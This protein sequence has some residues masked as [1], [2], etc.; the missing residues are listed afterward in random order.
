MY[1]QFEN[2]TPPTPPPSPPPPIPLTGTSR[3]PLTHNWFVFEL[4]YPFLEKRGSFRPSF[5]FFQE[6][7]TNL[8]RNEPRFGTIMVKSGP[9]MVQHGPQMVQNGPKLVKNGP[10]MVKN[11]P[12]MVSQV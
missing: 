10:K 4:F 5:V 9:K 6:K 8:G 2:I 1:Q 12:K 7:N 11:G 3:P